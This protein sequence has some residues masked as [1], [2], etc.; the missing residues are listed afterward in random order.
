MLLI[1]I[2]MTYK[3]MPHKPDSCRLLLFMGI[4]PGN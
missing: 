2:I 1:L 3:E 4:K